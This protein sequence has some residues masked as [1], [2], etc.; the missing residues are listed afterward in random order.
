MLA[1]QSDIAEK[2]TTVAET[3]AARLVCPRRAMQAFAT[4]I[5]PLRCSP[6]RDIAWSFSGLM[7]GGGPIEFAFSSNDDAL[8]YTVEVGGAE[9]AEHARLHAA[10]DLMTRLGHSVPD[11]PLLRHWQDVQAGSALQW[12]AW[13][14]VRY[15]SC[16]ERSKIYVEIPREKQ[17]MVPIPN[18]PLRGSRLHMIGYEPALGRY[19]FYFSRKF[20]ERRELESLLDLLKRTTQ[21]Q[22]LIEKLRY[23]CGIPVESL[24]RWF[25]LGYSLATER[26]GALSAL[27][28]FIRA[29][30]LL[31]GAPGLRQKLLSLQ[32]C[33][34]PGPSPYQ[35]LVGP[36]A[37]R[38]LPDHGMLTLGMGSGDQEVDLRVG[39]SGVALAKL[40]SKG[41]SGGRHKLESAPIA[42]QLI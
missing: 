26:V 14:G 39:I 28:L 4:C 41:S 9:L 17:S 7:A 22:R 33:R 5:E 32:C 1:N 2:V 27:A 21:Q 24:L 36:V 42:Q 6:W 37:D 3:L 18:S 35:E 15:D 20:A 25:T 34:A 40:F 38:D 8:R 13:L 11:H 16:G 30:R 31:G 10:C 23:M 29:K 12:G 19:E